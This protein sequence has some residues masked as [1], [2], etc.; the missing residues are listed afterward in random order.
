MQTAI[1]L[2]TFD[3]LH[4]GH[5][6]V[7]GLA[8]GYHTVAVT[9]GIPPKAFYDKNPKL[10]MMPEDKAAACLYGVAY[11]KS[12]MAKACRRIF[13]RIEGEQVALP[14]LR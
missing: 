3:G 6:A 9:F 14:R 5:R 1:V 10:L 13:R 12:R 7:I 4:G 11:R 8:S 2:G